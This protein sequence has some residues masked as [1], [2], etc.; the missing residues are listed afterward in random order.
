MKCVVLNAQSLQNKMTELK[1][2]NFMDR[3]Y[4][5]ISVTETWGN[6]KTPDVTYALKWYIMYRKDRLGQQGGGKILYIKQWN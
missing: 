6:E 1:S 3:N 4:H 5:I 2:K